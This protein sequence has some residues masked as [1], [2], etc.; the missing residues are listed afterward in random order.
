MAETTKLSVDKVLDKLR[1]PDAPKTKMAQFDEKIDSLKKEVSRMK[2]A[3]LRL[4]RGQRAKPTKQ[5]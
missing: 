2:A 5:D 1:R 4:E 3:R